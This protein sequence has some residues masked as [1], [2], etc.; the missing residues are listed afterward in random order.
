MRKFKGLIGDHFRYGKYYIYKKWDQLV[1]CVGEEASF[2]ATYLSVINR[3]SSDSRTC[4]E[5]HTP[6][7][8]VSLFGQVFVNRVFVFSIIGLIIVTSVSSPAKPVT[9]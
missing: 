2:L 6:L 3:R 8:L 5:N 1:R 9:V 4:V 7:S